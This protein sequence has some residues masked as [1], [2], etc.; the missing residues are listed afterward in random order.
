MQAEQRNHH[1]R[2]GCRAEALRARSLGSELTVSTYFLHMCR[3]LAF[4]I[5]C[6]TSSCHK[7]RVSEVLQSKFISTT[8]TTKRGTAIWSSWILPTPEKRLVV[9]TSG[10]HFEAARWTGATP[11]SGPL[12]S[13][14][15][16]LLM[17]RVSVLGPLS[18]PRLFWRDLRL[19]LSKCGVSIGLQEL[20]LLRRSER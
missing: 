5:S 2:A 18:W 1:Y 13:R 12:W 7:R 6:L 15:H 11:S 19:S 8:E 14:A 3:G 20:V 10:V 16:H 17:L 9:P 4:F